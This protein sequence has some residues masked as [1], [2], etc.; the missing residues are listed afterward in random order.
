MFK[1]AKVNAMNMMAW[2][3][4]I[5]AAQYALRK[6]HS[7]L[8]IS[9]SVNM[10][11]DVKVNAASAFIF[12]QGLDAIMSVCDNAPLTIIKQQKLTSKAGSQLLIAIENIAMLELKRLMMQIEQQHSLGRFMDI[13]VIGLNGRPVSRAMLNL[14][15]RQCMICTNN[16]KNCAR[17]QAHS[18][19]DIHTVIRKAIFHVK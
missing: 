4:E 13:D 11:G 14:E 9:F 7:P 5:A 15:P 12:Q 16:A 6:H 8:L 19:K 2:R 17:S 10:V 1:G 18:V 3:E